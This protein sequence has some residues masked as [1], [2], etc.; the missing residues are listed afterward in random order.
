MV[1]DKINSRKRFAAEILCGGSFSGVGLI[2]VHLR[3][4]A[5]QYRF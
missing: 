4:S 5:A 3:L 1:V 2:C